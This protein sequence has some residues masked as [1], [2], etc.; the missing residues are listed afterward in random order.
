MDFKGPRQNDSKAYLKYKLVMAR[1]IFKKQIGAHLNIKMYSKVTIITMR[2]DRRQISVQ[3]T[4]RS[5]QIYEYLAYD[6][7]SQIS[8]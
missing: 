7:A 1:N 8:M 4:S 6:K 3:S 5:S 2:C